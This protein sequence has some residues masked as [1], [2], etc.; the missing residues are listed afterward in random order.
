VHGGSYGCATGLFGGL[1]MDGL[2]RELKTRWRGGERD[3]REGSIVA[4]PAASTSSPA[5]P[6]SNAA[7]FL[8]PVS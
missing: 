7:F 4:D 2:G 8:F 6:A 1:G 5:G 3:V